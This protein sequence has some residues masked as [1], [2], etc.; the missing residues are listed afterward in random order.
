MGS[1][2]IL[3]GTDG[4]RGLAVASDH[5]LAEGMDPRRAYQERGLLTESFVEH[6]ALAAGRWL[7]ARV[8]EK[9]I[10]PGA[11]VFAWDPRD[12]EG[13]FSEAALRGLRRSGA[14]VLVAGVLPTPAAAVYQA[15][16]GAAGAVILTA[17]HNPA[18]ENGIK[19]FLAE[20]A[21]KPLPEEDAD[22]SA[23]VWDI[24]PED[25]EESPLLGPCTESGAEARGIYAG[26]LS[27]LPNAW[28]REGTLDGWDIVLDPGRGA[29]TALAGEI[30]GEMGPR[31]LRETNSVG[32][33]PVN[34]GGG[35][36]ALA[37]RGAV[38]G[39]EADLIASHAGLSALFAAG[40]A[41]R[42]EFRAGGGFAAAGVF[43]ADGDRCY[44]L[45]YD[46]FADAV[47]VLGGDE[48]VVLQARFLAAEGEIPEGGVGAVSIE[49][50]AGAVA[51]LAA[52]G[53]RVELTPVGDKWLL[54]AAERWGD[55]FVLGGEE[56]GHIVAPGLLSD[57][58]GRERRLAVGD[59]MKC[60]L[61]TCAAVGGMAAVHPLREVY[62]ALEAPFPRGYKKNL[63][64]Y[65]V[66]RTRF[67]PDEPAWEAVRRALEEE[68]SR[69]LPPGARPR[70]APLVD[71]PAVLCLSLDDAGGR[72]RAA[73]FVRNSG[74]ERRTGIT[75]RGPADWGGA[76]RAAG[77]AVLRELLGRLKDEADPLAR[78]EE[79]LLSELAK[80]SA[81]PE[82]LDADL[83]RDAAGRF[84]VEVPP[85]RIRKE[86]LRGG[87]VQEEGGRL[88]LS[89]LGRWFMEARKNR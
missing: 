62:A 9:L 14:H 2:S 80:G 70:W 71:D 25:V 85:G 53:L 61:N 13:R 87:L 30:A 37:G 6:Y 58:W 66:D 8:P 76:L 20:G 75:L 78:M 52:A 40:R 44:T 35:V 74:T 26:H 68:I 22:L 82:R 59:G 63:Y 38:G 33:G 17:S 50:D 56:S 60:F 36:V 34:E 5:P 28:L 32:E 16:A 84:G 23:L 31:S 54:R 64:A 77:E 51:A 42:E 45:F 11:I 24:L 7:L 10:S 69:N 83:G 48:A 89:A 88:A 4:I 72:S 81:S 21:R 3:Q 27:R 18:E 55:D 79:A 15:A 29:L 12:S 67:A 1:F 73:V 86:A 65:H 43:D 46:P 39:K 49:S 19:I 57:A 41:R 47:R